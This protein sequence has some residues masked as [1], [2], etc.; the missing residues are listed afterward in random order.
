VATAVIGL[1]FPY[2][3]DTVTGVAVSIGTVCGLALLLDL[4]AARWQFAPASRQLP[5][6]Q[7]CWSARVRASTKGSS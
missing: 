2:F 3:T 4:P 6:T 1:R 7:E 5:K